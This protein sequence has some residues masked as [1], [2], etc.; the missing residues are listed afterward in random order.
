[1]ELPSEPT[2]GDQLTEVGTQK[3]PTPER[4]IGRRLGS[5]AC[6]VVAFGSLGIASGAA[7]S[8]VLPTEV[9]FGPGTAK[10]TISIDGK[11]TLDMGPIAIRKEFENTPQIGPLKLGVTFK[12]GEIPT[13][14]EVTPG[15]AQNHPA[16][17]QEV[18]IASV[19]NKDDEERIQQYGEL[20]RSVSRQSNDIQHA[21]GWHLLQLSLVSSLLLA[22]PYIFRKEII[23]AAKSK[24]IGLLVPTAALVVTSLIVPT[25]SSRSWRPV[26]SAY[27]GTPLEGVEVSGAPAEEVINRY[28]DRVM[29]YVRQ[30]DEFYQDALQSTDDQLDY[31]TLL[32][33][34]SQDTEG[35]TILFFTDNHCNTGIPKL[36]AM[37]A[38]K[39][40]AKLVVDGGD[41]VFGG[42]GTE[43]YCVEQEMKAFNKRRVSVIQVPGN[44]GGP[45]TSRYMRRNHAKVLL[46]KPITV[47]GLTFIG[48]ADPRQSVIGKQIEYRGSERLSDLGTRLADLACQQDPGAI[49]VVHDKRA[50]NEALQRGCTNLTLSGHTHN[51]EVVG[52][53]RD[54][55]TKTFRITGG[56]SGGADENHLTYGPLARPGEFMLLSVNQKGELLARQDLEITTG[57]TFVAGEIIDVQA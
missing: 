46:G 13:L 42:T 18:E 55:G 45:A 39:A 31:V 49:V 44:H 15:Q 20:Y 16:G 22:T 27:Q 6:K 43:Q 19:F 40:G 51:E 8:T 53:V 56:S 38:D 5:F 21:L 50:A 41:T 29:R 47:H 9:P 12:P 23:A 30:T 54:D 57:G 26:S 35:T 11:Q 25:K 17:R 24:P 52:G 10:A 7:L 2:T 14:P 3:E 32:G 36:L 37:V 34:R 28:G 4:H 33:Q 48:D 1:M